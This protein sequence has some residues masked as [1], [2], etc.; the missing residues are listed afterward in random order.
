[1][2]RELDGRKI[3]VP[4]TRELALLV[5]MLEERGAKAIPCPLVGIHDAPDPAPVE[6]WIGRFNAGCEDLILVTGEGL[7]RLHGF[8]QRAGLEAGFIA[9]LRMVRKITRGPKPVKALREIG[10]GSDLVASA[11]TTDGVI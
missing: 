7:R 8:A 11:P 2:T 4:E 3:I 10:L 1:M 6:A 5:A 9:R